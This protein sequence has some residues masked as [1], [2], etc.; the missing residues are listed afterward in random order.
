VGSDARLATHV[1]D[2]RKFKPAAAFDLLVCVDA[3]HHIGEPVEVLSSM[4][5]L[6]RPGGMLVGNIWTADHFHEFQRLRHG[7]TAHTLKSLRFCVDALR[8]RTGAHPSSL[9]TEL[10]RADELRSRLRMQ[11]EI[12]HC[13]ESR[14]WLRF[15]VLV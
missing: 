1:G 10:V 4:S 13:G 9:R 3:L 11:F 12:V 2:V 15:V 5:R 7:P 8:S 14:Y 6:V